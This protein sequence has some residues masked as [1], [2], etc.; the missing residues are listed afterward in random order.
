MKNWLNFEVELFIY[1]LIGSI[2]TDMWIT[3]PSHVGRA[4][5]FY[6]LTIGLITGCLSAQRPNIV[7]IVADDLVFILLSFLQC[8]WCKLPRP[9]VSQSGPKSVWYLVNP[10][11]DP[12]QPDLW[13]IPLIFCV[14]C[15]ET[16]HWSENMS[17]LQ[18]RYRGICKF[19]RVSSNLK[20]R[21]S[22]WIINFSGEKEWL[23][24]KN[25][26][27]FCPRDS[28]NLRVKKSDSEKIRLIHVCFI[29][30]FIY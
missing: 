30:L 12:S 19:L 17:V 4:A 5:L 20:K 28:V 25:E 7:V 9:K 29:Y 16:I 1:R 11:C 22:E 15:T 2:I 6:V 21:D 18:Y 3:T 14:A 8:I 13:S 23:R 27:Q 26:W 24:D 10:V